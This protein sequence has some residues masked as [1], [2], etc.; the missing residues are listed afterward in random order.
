MT[1]GLDSVGA[2]EKELMHVLSVER[3]PD[4]LE[5]PRTAFRFLFGFASL[6]I[7]STACVVGR[8]RRRVDRRRQGARAALTIQ[9][10]PSTT[11][12]DL[13]H[14]AIHRLFVPRR[15]DFPRRHGRV[16]DGS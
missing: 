8:H 3:A 11:G 16:R 4:L 2:D 7:A 6:R 10:D 14:A 12:S 5:A 9:F 13:L 15:R 1:R